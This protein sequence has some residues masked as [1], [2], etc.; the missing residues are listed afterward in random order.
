VK[1]FTA[2]APDYEEVTMAITQ[3]KPDNVDTLIDSSDILVIDFWAPWCGPCRS[4]KPIFEAAAERHP[5]VTFVA[6]NTEDEQ[7]I[8][9]AFKIQSIPTVM[10]FRQGVLLYNQPGLHPAPVLEDLL[11]K[12]KALD[13]A[14]IQ[15][16]IAA[17]KQATSN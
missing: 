10:I 4:F 13:M 3:L 16:E 11:G 7:E 8:A 1:R 14:T 2:S 12:V 9:G 17:K 6:C 15:A 5:D